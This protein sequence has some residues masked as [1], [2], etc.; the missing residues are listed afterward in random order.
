ML[1]HGRPGQKDYFREVNPLDL[2]RTALRGCN[3][4]LAAESNSTIEMA[5]LK[6]DV[7]D[8]LLAVNRLRR[9]DREN[10]KRGK[11]PTALCSRR[12]PRSRHS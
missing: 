4:L 7:A 2:I 11:A 3:E 8:A 1:K 12:L 5:A 6:N 10:V 9:T